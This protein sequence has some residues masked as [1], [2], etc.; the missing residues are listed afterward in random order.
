MV[1]LLIAVNNGNGIIQ[2]VRRDIAMIHALL[3]NHQRGIQNPP[4]E[5][6][7]H[8]APLINRAAPHLNQNLHPQAPAPPQLQAQQPPPDGHQP[9]LR[10]SNRNRRAPDR[11]NL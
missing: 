5:A 2:I 4:P 8:H 1:T 6:H 10:R 9:I 3:R 7:Q 11:L